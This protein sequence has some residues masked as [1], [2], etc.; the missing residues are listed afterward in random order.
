MNDWRNKFGQWCA[1]DH[2]GVTFVHRPAGQAFC[3]AHALATRL[4]FDGKRAVAIGIHAA[5]ATEPRLREAAP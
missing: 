4:G 5:L 3:S 1:R 2:A